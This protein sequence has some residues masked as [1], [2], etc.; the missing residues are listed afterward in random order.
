MW[1]SF[2]LYFFIFTGIS[3]R[4]I[5]LVL[6]KILNISPAGDLFSMTRQFIQKSS[7]IS[8]LLGKYL[9]TSHPRDRKI[10]CQGWDGKITVF[11]SDHPQAVKTES[12]KLWWHSQTSQPSSRPHLKIWTDNQGP[13]DLWFFVCFCFLISFVFALIAHL[14]VTRIN[15]WD[16]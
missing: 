9:V 3:R 15:T 11:L 14:C 10:M 16:N 1:R 5:H 8:C 6:I 13:P 12:A 2:F 4:I 7:L